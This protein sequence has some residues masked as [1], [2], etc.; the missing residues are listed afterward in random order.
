ML[1]LEARYGR[2]RHLPTG[3]AVVTTAGILPARWV[4]HAVGPIWRGGGHDEPELLASAYRS[5]MARADEV[6]ARS[7]ALPA[8]S[9]GVYGYPVEAAAGIALEVVA[10]RLAASETLRRATF[11]LYSFDTFEVF[12]NAIARLRSGDSGSS[13]APGTSSASG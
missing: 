3:D 5:A 10:D 6:G 4:I 7:L 8:I 1:D 9:C 2:D 11:V 13:P 12:R